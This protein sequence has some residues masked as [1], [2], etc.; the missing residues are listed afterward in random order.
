LTACGSGY[1]A[2]VTSSEYPPENAEVVAA[3]VERGQPVPWLLLELV[4]L[5]S[6]PELQDLIDPSR[7]LRAAR[8]ST[9]GGL[10]ALTV[11]VGVSGLVALG[12]AGRTTARGYFEVTPW[13][14]VGTVSV[15]LG[16]VP[17][18]GLAVVALRGRIGFPGPGHF[19]LGALGGVLALGCWIVLF[20]RS[21]EAAA[22]DDEHGTPWRWGVLATL[23]VAVAVVALVL[24]SATR[25]TAPETK[26]EAEAGDAVERAPD[27]PAPVDRWTTVDAVVDEMPPWTRAAL[28]RELGRALDDLEA[29]GVLP[30]EEAQRARNASLGH[31]ARVMQEPVDE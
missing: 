4:A 16:L 15:Y 29:R 17:L 26:A 13:S 11:V 27:E 9:G 14:V 1:A 22:W 23:L 3:G 24:R 12:L 30:R 18:L 31:L 6:R 21:P 10:V 19:R 25:M 7:R 8:R 28:G 5:R 20:S 2:A